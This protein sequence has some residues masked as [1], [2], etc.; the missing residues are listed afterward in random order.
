M[1][2]AGKVSYDDL[3]RYYANADLF[4]SPATGSES[5]GIVLM[6]AMAAGKPVVASDIEGYRGI[7][8][9]GNQGLL[10]PRK[11][12]EA[13]TNCL[14]LLIENPELAQRL[15]ANGRRTVEQYRWEVVASQVEAYYE[16]CL[17]G[18]NGFLK[19]RAV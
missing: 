10:F 17:R 15:G 1:V 14:A 4:C 3:A 19:Q 16:D 7:M 6:E 5:F 8:E 12:A 13:L 11:D 18:A 9:H 2:F